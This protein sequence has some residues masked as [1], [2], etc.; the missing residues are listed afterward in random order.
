MRC[1]SLR[2]GKA[3]AARM[4]WVGLDVVRQ[5]F[6]KVRRGRDACGMFRQSRSLTDS[7]GAVWWGDLWSGS[8]GVVRRGN[9]C[10]GSLG[11]V[12]FRLA[13]LGWAGLHWNGSVWIGK[14]GIEM[15]T[16]EVCNGEMRYETDGTG[17]VWQSRRGRLR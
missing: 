4:L 16:Q 15:A 5:E 13:R 10:L 6:A 11:Q 3:V 14:L 2:Q 9:E 7:T 17:E 12:R 1:G 8:T